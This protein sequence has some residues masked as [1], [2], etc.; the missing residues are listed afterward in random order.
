MATI[1]LFQQM[2]VLYGIRKPADSL[3]LDHHIHSSYE[4]SLVERTMQYVKDRT[5]KF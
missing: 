2:V 1:I 4:K 5:E 3:K